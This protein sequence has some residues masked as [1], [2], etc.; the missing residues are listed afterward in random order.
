VRLARRQRVDT[1]QQGARHAAPVDLED[2]TVRA[3]EE[4][5]L[6]AD[7]VEPGTC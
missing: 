3:D 7:G 6:V 2:L 4:R 5:V 1:H